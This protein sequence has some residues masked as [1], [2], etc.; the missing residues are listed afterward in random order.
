MYVEPVD[1]GVDE[2]NGLDEDVRDERANGLP[3]EDAQA[4]E[5]LQDGAG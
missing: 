5:R 2:G 1:E 3:S 4:L